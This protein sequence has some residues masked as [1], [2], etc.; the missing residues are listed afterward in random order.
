LFAFGIVAAIV[1]LNVRSV[2]SSQLVEEITVWGKILVLVALAGIGIAR[3]DSANLI[4]TDQESLGVMGV[5]IGAAAVFM[6]YEGFQLVTYDYDDIANPDATLRRAV[7]VAVVVVIAIYIAV[8][9]GSASLAGA[10][11]LISNK[12]VALA[13]AGQ[14]AAGT[15]GL[16]AITIAAVFS[17]ASAINA[18]LFATARLA[19]TVGENRQL[20]RRLIGRNSHGM[21]VLAVLWLGGTAGVLAA[22]VGLT[23]LVAAASLVFLLTFCTVCVIAARQRSTAWPVF[24]VGALLAVGL[25]IVLAVHLASETPIALTAVVVAVLAS[26]AGGRL[27]GRHL[28]AG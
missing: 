23:D 13:T 1:A 28:R 15:L 8:A 20:P 5:V 19:G 14:E 22:V 11:A 17:T 3:F 21:P 6:A 18:T 26:I 9:V 25:A 16:I 7:P 12:E 24:A 27:L 4:L 2:N 10:S